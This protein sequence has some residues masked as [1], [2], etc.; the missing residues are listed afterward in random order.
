[1]ADRAAAGSVYASST[2]PDGRRGSIGEVPYLRGADS[3]PA[4]RGRPPRPGSAIP[5]SSGPGRRGARRSCARCR[6]G[7]R[8]RDSTAPR[9]CNWS[10]S[11]SR[12]VS[13][14]TPFGPVRAG[15]AER[16]QHLRRRVGVP[17]GLEALEALERQ[18]RLGDGD[19]GRALGERP[20]DRQ[21]CA[22]QLHRHLGPDET[23]QGVVQTR[24]R[25]SRSRS[26]AHL[27]LGEGGSGSEVG[28]PLRVGDAAQARRG[29]RGGVDSRL[30][31]GGRRRAARAAGRPSSSRRPRG[32]RR[33]DLPWPVRAG[34]EHGRFPLGRSR[35]RRG[36][37]QRRGAPRAPSR[38][39]PRLRGGPGGPGG[40][41]GG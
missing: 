5:A 3:A 11:A 25:I 10:T 29:P 2:V 8:S 38:A 28:A 19:L 34:R 26:D 4:P 31:R 30:P 13:A 20:R 39:R 41:R 9:R 23:L 15:R 37:G 17:G 32:P 36:R 1:M 7:R 18:L 24:A 14:P 40:H 16:S 33:R 21:A 12:L 6:A 27:P 35:G 22:R